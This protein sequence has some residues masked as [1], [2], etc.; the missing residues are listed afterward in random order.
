M[1]R[2]LMAAALAACLAGPGA[3]NEYTTYVQLPVTPLGASRDARC[4]TMALLNLPAAWHRGDAIVV[5]LTAGPAHNPQR[6]P[7]IA[8]F[9]AEQAA[10]LEV[11]PAMPAR[12]A[13]GSPEAA[14][15]AQRTDPLDLVFG[16][17]L[18]ARQQAGGGLVVA[19]GHGPGG[20][21]ALAAADD[22]EA[23]ARLG[24]DGPRFAAALAIGD[25]RRRF[26]LG[27]SQAAR[28]RA[29][30]RLGLL[31]EVLA[32]SGARH[33]AENGQACTMDLEAGAVSVRAAFRH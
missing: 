2:F 5:M 26:R 28:E 29:E 31:C 15:L 1:R 22:A 32:R 10:V 30:L 27:A 11:S 18:A 13:D 7:L 19:V 20:T 24:P 25:D 6:D 21:L 4:D 23:S 9:L 16:G 17:L 33:G 14:R 3:A 8:A 12:C